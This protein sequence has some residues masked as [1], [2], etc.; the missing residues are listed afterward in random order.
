MNRQP[1]S[2]SNI[3]SVGWENETLEVAFLNGRI[4]RYDGVPQSV[5]QAVVGA[6]SVGSE[7]NRLVKGRYVDSEV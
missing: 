1:V 3:E 5:F 6:A 7:F 4:Y 2:S